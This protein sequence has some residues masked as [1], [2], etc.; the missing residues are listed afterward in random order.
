MSTVFDLHDDAGELVR[1]ATS[2]GDVSGELSAAA[3]TV[4]V[5]SARVMKTWEGESGTTYDEHRKRLVASLDR[6]ASVADRIAVTMGRSAGAVRVA[7]GH[8]DVQ[9]GR[10]ASVPHV[11]GFLGL[12]LVFHPEDDAQRTKVEG[13][14][15]AAEGIRADLDRALETDRGVLSAATTEWAAISAEWQGVASGS[16]PPFVLPAEGD[17]TGV[18]TS[19]DQT[20]VNTGSGDDDVRVFVDPF[21]GEQVVIVNGTVYRFPPGQHITV[22][23]GGGNDT[24]HISENTSLDLTVIGGEGD[25]AIDG[26]SGDDTIIG[27]GGDDDIDA[28]SGDDY[29]SGGAGGDYI[30]GQDGDDDLFGG[31]DDDTVYGLGGADRISG[32]EGDD[33]LE[34]GNDDDRLDGG[35]G[36]DVVSGGN[37]DDRIL[38]GSG[39]DVTY[40]GRGDDT[41]YGGTGDDTAHDE[42]GD[43]AHGVEQVV[44]VQIPG[45]D[46]FIRV[47]GSEEF[48]ARV[49]A[50]LDLLASSPRGRMLLDNLQQH[51][52]DSGFL[53]INK[54]SLTIR[55][56]DDPTDPNNS[57]A[58]HS[59]NDYEINLNVRLD[60]L[61][62]P[63]GPVEGPPIAVLQHELAH[64]Y[65]YANDTLRDGQYHGDDTL[66]DG[67]NVRERQA[68]GLPIDHDDDPSTPEIID[69]DHPIEYTENG[70]R[71]EMGVDH[72]D[73]Y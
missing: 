33:Y 52:D 54:S 6:A 44:R 71:E 23:A 16:V 62:T 31:A 56:Y 40:A 10:V 18:I 28:G 37:D 5:G 1:A 73:H 47:E 46:Y 64:V 8:L 55:E 30:D 12:P 14:I 68:A 72:R 17:R 63:G 42:S 53:G 66:N 69:P 38:G 2:W 7:Q 49:Q 70:L 24:I 26:G 29:V 61:G 32:G 22:R 51:H 4:T 50:D 34:G 27:L 25:D 21:T 3:D 45:D 43:T 20:V 58:S 36:D 48:K 13:V 9:W 67:T 41:T 65:D 19:G 11:G 59:G 60:E 35:S 39:D 57:T 15:A